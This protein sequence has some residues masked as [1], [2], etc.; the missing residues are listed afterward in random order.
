MYQ[1]FDLLAPVHKGLRHALGGLVFQA[2]ALNANDEGA[3]K[4]F[5]EEFADI[6]D[7]LESHSRDEDA[8][9]HHL[10]E[11]FAPETAAKLEAEHEGLEAELR[12]LQRLLDK[13]LR[14]S[15]AEERGPTWYIL[16]R[17]LT[18]FTTE[19]FGHLEREEGEAAEALWANLDD[20]QLKDVSVRIR[21]SIPPATMMIFL[22]YMLPALNFYER[23]DMLSGMK[24]FAPP[25]AYRAVRELAEQ[26]LRPEDWAELANA[27]DAVEQEA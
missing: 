23:Y 24:R 22:R 10:Y 27:L 14:A 9:V 4:R 21:S 15:S 6:V 11:R 25:E 16:Q 19:Y 1:R 7:I 18:K 26:R 2:G 17:K 8:H 20:A 5:A 3:L 13:T 12:E